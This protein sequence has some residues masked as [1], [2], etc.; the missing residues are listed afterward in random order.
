MSLKS[1]EPLSALST[2]QQG[3]GDSRGDDM[4]V[5]GPPAIGVARADA[6]GRP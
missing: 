4:A 1:I 6:A 2:Y 5:V 3:D